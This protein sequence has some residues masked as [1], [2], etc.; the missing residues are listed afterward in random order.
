MELVAQGE[1][2]LIAICGGD[3]CDGL[4]ASAQSR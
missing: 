3:A 1:N 4:Q 2:V